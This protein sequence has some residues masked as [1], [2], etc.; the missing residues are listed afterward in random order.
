MG[1]F[2]DLIGVLD[3]FFSLSASHSLLHCKWSVR[4]GEVADVR[5]AM[6]EGRGSVV[7]G[8]RNTILLG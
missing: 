4:F 5:V 6:V 8:R 2:F 3:S 1:S 7:R